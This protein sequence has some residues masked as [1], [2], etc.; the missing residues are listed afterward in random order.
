MRSK[1][2]STLILAVAA[3]AAAALVAPAEEAA[4]E[5]QALH[6]LEVIDESEF[7]LEVE[8]TELEFAPRPEEM[9]EGETNVE[10]LLFT[11]TPVERFNPLSPRFSS[12]VSNPF[13]A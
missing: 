12:E 1:T 4:I 3:L 8:K 9:D 11:W 7:R 2:E 10:D 13:L 6:E 5:G